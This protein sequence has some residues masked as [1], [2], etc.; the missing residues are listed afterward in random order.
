MPDD[1]ELDTRLSALAGTPA[2][3]LPGAAAARARGAQRTRRKRAALA[4]AGSVIAVLALTAGAALSGGTDRVV[5]PFADAGPSAPTEEGLSASL[6]DA[7]DVAGV[8]SG[9]WQL[10]QT[11]DLPLDPFPQ[12]CRGSTMFLDDPVQTAIRLL[13]GPGP[14]I[15]GHRLAGYESEAAAE[16][17]L[18]RLIDA[19]EL[20]DRA[21]PTYGY[22]LVGG[23][24]GAGPSRVY[25]RYLAG[26]VRVAFALERI[27]AVL[28][29]VALRPGELDDTL[30]DL[31]DAAAHEVRGGPFAA[32]EPS[33]MKGPPP[34]PPA[35]ATWDAMDALLTAEDTTSVEPGDWVVSGVPQERLL[36]PCEG[37]TRYPTDEA[38]E[39]TDRRGL[40][41]RREAGGTQVD[42]EVYRY[43]SAQDAAEAVAGYRRAV[44]ECPS[45]PETGILGGTRTHEIVD[46]AGDGK[47]YVRVLTEC[48]S[49]APY[50]SYLAV[51]QVDDGVAVLSVVVGE[52]GGTGLGLAVSYAEVA[53]AA[54]RRAQD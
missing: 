24:R 3:T 42:Q 32:P 53:A 4:V 46:S 23:L 40:E 51:V 50:P 1:D 28:S 11:Y 20:C 12:G 54:L 47:L 52:D 7:D 8:L 5:A 2:G 37:G 15:L 13:D 10:R 27:G 9:D 19:V 17:A 21:S 41:V 48:P 38:V 14:S 45:E 22:E 33:L 18:G 25:G 43:A 36:D 44:A 39:A 16:A 26:D 31:A 30:P 49:C 35:P 34:P 6:L 29:G